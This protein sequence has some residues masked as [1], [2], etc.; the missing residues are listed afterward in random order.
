MRLTIFTGY[1]DRE[2]DGWCVFARSVC[3]TTPGAELIRLPAMQGDGSNAFTY[4][5]FMVP[6]L[7]GY[8]GW[9]IFMDGVD[10]LALSDLNG[11]MA[12]AD[13]RY[14][15]QVVQHDYKTRHPRKYVGST[16]ECANEDYPCK[17]WSSV[18]LWN[19]AH[20]SH[21]WLREE[22]PAAANHRFSWLD[23]D[24]IGA[25]PLAWNWLVDEYDENKD[26]NVLHWTAGAPFLEHYRHAPMADYWHKVNESLEVQCA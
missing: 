22:A 25:L 20:P 6:K 23:A 21:Q 4:S 12:L 2:S 8:R 5:R 24:E 1:D 26:A 17:N 3:D 18:I 13:P 15:V 9:A 19:C 16:M 7:C 14:G 11:L 10:M